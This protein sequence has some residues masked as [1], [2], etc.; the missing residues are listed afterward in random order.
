MAGNVIE[1]TDAAFD[2]VVALMYR[3]WSI[4]GHPGAG[5]AK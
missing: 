2:E 3:C 4:S 5:L 1:L